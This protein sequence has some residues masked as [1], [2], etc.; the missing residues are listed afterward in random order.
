VLDRG[1]LVHIHTNFGDELR[2]CHR[3]RNGHIRWFSEERDRPHHQLSPLLQQLREQQLHLEDRMNVKKAIGAVKENF[4]SSND[5]LFI[6]LI[7]R[8]LFAK[9]G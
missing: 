4:P 7:Y 2:G 8:I 9:N 6:I 5:Y 3:R 1:K